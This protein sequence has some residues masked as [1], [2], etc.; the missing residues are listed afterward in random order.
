MD[1]YNLVHG[2][3]SGINDLLRS[4]HPTQR[5]QW[6]ASQSGHT[7]R[8]ARP[9]KEARMKAMT[10]NVY[11]ERARRTTVLHRDSGQP[12]MSQ[13]TTGKAL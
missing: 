6:R 9:W 1:N 8:L 2:L 10:S 7:G 3:H 12:D 11:T 13:V 4:H 5:H